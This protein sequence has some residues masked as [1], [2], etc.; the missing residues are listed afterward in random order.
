[1][2]NIVGGVGEGLSRSSWIRAW[3]FTWRE[4]KVQICPKTFVHDCRNVTT[5]WK[6]QKTF[7]LSHLKSIFSWKSNGPRRSRLTLKRFL[8]CIIKCIHFDNQHHSSCH[9]VDIRKIHVSELRLRHE[10]IKIIF[11]VR[12]HLA[13][14]LL[15]PEK[16][17][18][19]KMA[20]QPY[21]LRDTS[22][23]A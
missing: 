12:K 22:A 9:V 2:C 6:E 16:G 13:I 23:L 10:M 8:D 18:K 4:W 5:I 1:M 17:L 3:R 19:D 20:F 15:W 14:F 21:D 11:A 7:Y